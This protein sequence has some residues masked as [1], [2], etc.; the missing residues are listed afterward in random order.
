MEA[1]T[2][3]EMET[4]IIFVCLDT[5]LFLLSPSLYSPSST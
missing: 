4:A 2:E 5:V 1:D 3:T